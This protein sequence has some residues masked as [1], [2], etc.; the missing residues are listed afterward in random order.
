LD[1]LLRKNF[2][3]ISERFNI[4]H[5]IW[6]QILEKKVKQWWATLECYEL[7]M[8]LK[9]SQRVNI[10]NHVHLRDI[11]NIAAILWKRIWVNI[12]DETTLYYD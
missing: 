12:Y 4:S 3:N 8:L 10:L 6:I 5:V 2:V 7:N 9:N 1:K 11:S